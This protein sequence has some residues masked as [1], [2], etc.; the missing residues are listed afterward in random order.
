MKK[1]IL[2][3]SAIA[4]GLISA[5]AFAAS[6][7][8]NFQ[9]TATLNGACVISATN[10][11]FGAV[12]P[13]ATGNATANGIVTYTCS[14]GIVGDVSISAGSSGD[15]FNRKMSGS[16]G[17]TDKLAYALTTNNGV[18]TSSGGETGTYFGSFLGS[19][20]AKTITVTGTMALNQYLKPDAYTD[21]LTVTLSY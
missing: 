6:T 17:N 3:M 1:S 14:R 7:S 19:G 4:L 13:S 8:A 18:D 21:S 12:T 15:G 20:A 16:N 5:Q 2:G 10:V 11:A 9:T